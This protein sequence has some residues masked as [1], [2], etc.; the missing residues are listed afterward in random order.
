MLTDIH[1]Y[2][3]THI[4]DTN[5]CVFQ[6]QV[7]FAD[8]GLEG[9]DRVCAG[10]PMILGLFW[11]IIRSLL[12]VTHTAGASNI[13]MDIAVQRMGTGPEFFV[14]AALDG[15]VYIHTYIRIYIHT[16]IHTYVYTY[17]HAYSSF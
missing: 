11:I 1:T 3:Y 2:V 5:L 14:S 15:T 10:I 12:T 4:Q 8:C 6:T 16:Y 17:I 7:T 13:T 9:L